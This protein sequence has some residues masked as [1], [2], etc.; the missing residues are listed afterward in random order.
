[1]SK[2]KITDYSYSKAKKYDVEIF[3]SQNPNK[4]IDVFKNN[5]KVAT[6]GDVKYDDYPNYLIKRGKKYA[7][8]RRRLYRK[9][10]GKDLDYDNGFYA[11]NILW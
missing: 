3:P 9:R 4:K 10:H 5:K 6:I 8:E 2:Y 11:M 1:M 7:N